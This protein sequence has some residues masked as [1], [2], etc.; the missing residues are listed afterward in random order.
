MALSKT[1]IEREIV[2]AIKINKKNI[3]D[4]CGWNIG[5]SNIEFLEKDYD[6]LRRFVKKLFKEED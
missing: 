5:E 2:K 1:Y 3:G 6:D 4:E